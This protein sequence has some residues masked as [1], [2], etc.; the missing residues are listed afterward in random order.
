MILNERLF[1]VKKLWTQRCSKICRFSE[2]LI[3]MLLVL[4]VF[5]SADEENEFQINDSIKEL[6]FPSVYVE[7][8]WESRYVSEG[9]DYL[10]GD[11]IFA[12]FTSIGYGDFALDASFR[13][14][15]DI[16]YSELN[17]GP[18][19]EHAFDDFTLS[20]YYYNLQFIRED[21]Q[22]HEVG[23]GFLYH[24]LPWN[25]SISAN[26]Y[27]SFRWDGAF[28]LLS[29]LWDYEII[30]GLFIQPRAVLGINN[31]YVPE[32]HNGPDHFALRLDAE[33]V[34][35]DQVSLTAYIGY[36]REIGKES[37]EQSPG[38]Y[39]LGNF[40]WGGLGIAFYF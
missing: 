35:T 8:I 23:V 19:Y 5:L 2:F 38:D 32:A 40:V 37:F 21:I 25:L 27:Y 34:L 15:L 16:K 17:I 4:P 22:D 9:R 24:G 3:S 12:T 26:T 30:E 18:S 39:D 1:R 10:E 36:N 6:Q 11:G 13:E 7:T 33:Y 31:G 29:V 14:G 28:S 20:A